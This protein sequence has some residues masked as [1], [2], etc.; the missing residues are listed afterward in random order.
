MTNESLLKLVSHYLVV[1]N[2]SA[3]VERDPPVDKGELAGGRLQPSA[4]RV[5]GGEELLR[6]VRTGVV[7][8]TINRRERSFKR[9]QR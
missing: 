7:R 3:A 6:G 4:V 9:M 8:K 5:A 2:V 1:I